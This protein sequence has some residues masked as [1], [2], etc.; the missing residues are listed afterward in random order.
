[1]IKELKEVSAMRT[2]QARGKAE[3]AE[4]SHTN[5]GSYLKQG[6]QPWKGVW[7][8]DDVTYT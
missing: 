6:G 5:L 3:G 8:K 7:E 2:W 4:T 1:M